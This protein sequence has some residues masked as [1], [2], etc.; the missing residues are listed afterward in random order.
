VRVQRACGVLEATENGPAAH[1]NWRRAASAARLA[2]RRLGDARAC[3]LFWRTGD[4]GSFDSDGWAKG[5]LDE[6]RAVR[7]FWERTRA[8]RRAPF[9]SPEL[10]S[11][12]R[13]SAPLRRIRVTEPVIATRQFAKHA[14]SHMVS[15]PH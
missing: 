12:L 10:V 2:L 4:P 7:R 15:K 3:G 11:Y 1:G 5:P 8:L 9:R 13:V 6:V 14:S